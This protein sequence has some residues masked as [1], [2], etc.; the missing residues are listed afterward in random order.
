MRERIK[1]CKHCGVEFNANSYVKKRVGGY[2]NECPDC[3]VEL[4]TETAVKY[5]GVISGDGKMAALSIVKFESDADADAYVRSF[6]S[7]G[8]FGGRKT[9]NCNSIKH[10]HVGTN[11][12][13]SNHKGKSS[14][15]DATSV[16]KQHIPN[17]YRN[18][19]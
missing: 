4:E 16:R 19:Y 2:I 14:G 10:E 15:D 1:E 3:V 12:G 18:D 17:R 6:N 9:N 11:M 13:N 8:S 5:R 7:C